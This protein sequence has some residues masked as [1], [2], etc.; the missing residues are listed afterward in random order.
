MGHVTANHGLQR[1]QM[2]AEEVLATKVVT[3]VLGD[4]A[5]RQGRADPRQA[6]AGA[7]LA[8]PG[9]GGR[10]HR[11]PRRRAAPATI[12]MPQA[13][14]CSRWPP[15]AT[16][17][18]SPARRMPAST[19]WPAIRTRRS[20][21]SLRSATPGQFGAPGTGDTRPR[22]FPRR[23]RRPAVR[24][25]AGGR[26]CARHHLPASRARRHL[27]GA[28][29][30]RHRQFGSRRSPRPARA[31]WR[32]AS[33]AWRSTRTTPLADYVRSGWVA[34]LDAAS[35]RPTTINGNEAA[36]ARAARRR[37]A[38]RHHGDPRRRPGLPAADRRAGGQQRA[39]SASRARWRQFPGAERRGEG[40]AEA[41]AHPGRDGASPARPSARLAAAMI[42]VDR[43]LDLFRV[44]NALA[45]RRHGLGRRQG[46]DHHR[47]LKRAV[48]HKKTGSTCPG[49]ARRPRAVDA[50]GS[51]R[52]SKAGLT[53]TSAE[54]QLLQRA[55]L[56]LADALLGDAERLAERFQRGAFVAQPPFA[57]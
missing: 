15:T 17:A 52:L 18:T 19:S 10:R 48:P 44:L 42:G 20:A 50:A 28:A 47:S 1:Q 8:Q 30:L 23:H 53:L 11:H 31:T 51:G 7:V 34:G 2:E 21:S 14:S 46:Q 45:P 16:C 4:S 27:L 43:K 5:V 40:G 32:S 41:A 9:A 54:L 13:A 37:L 29:R 26:L 57:G 6:Q 38:I 56:D 55:A 35:V 49:T 22:R 36:T 25:H 3:D 39:R 33:T 12:P 24:R